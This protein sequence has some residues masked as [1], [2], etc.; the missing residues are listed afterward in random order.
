MRR[1]LGLT[2]RRPATLAAG[3]LLMGGRPT[4]LR[5]AAR[6]GRLPA[7]ARRTGRVSDPRR[8]LLRHALFL[9]AFVLLLVLDA[10]SL[11]RHRASSSGSRDVLDEL[12]GLLVLGLARDVRLRD[13]ADE[14][15]VVLY[16]RQA[17]DLVARHE[18]KRLVQVLLG[19]DRDQILRGDLADWY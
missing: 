15:A 6:A 4:L 16:H 14:P 5:A 7:S 19:I 9:Q 17:P 1:P 3:G 13:N 10:R 8:A 18:A 11:V 12:A 2:C